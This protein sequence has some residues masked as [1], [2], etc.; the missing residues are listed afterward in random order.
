MEKTKLAALLLGAALMLGA[1]ATSV[2]AAEGKCGAGKCGGKTEK[3]GAGKKDAKAGKCGAKE[4]AK[5]DQSEKAAKCG[6]GKCG[7]KKDKSAK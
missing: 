2:F 4:G 5:A 6:A 7:G 1:G 3:C